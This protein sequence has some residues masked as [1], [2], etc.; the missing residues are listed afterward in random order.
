MIS[1]QMTSKEI[2]ER[3]CADGDNVWQTGDLSLRRQLAIII[4]AW[5]DG[6]KNIIVNKMAGKGDIVDH[7]VFGDYDLV[8]WKVHGVDT[9]LDPRGFM[10]AISINSGQNDPTDPNTQRVK[11]PGTF[12]GHIPG[13][14]MTEI[15]QKWID[16][17]GRIAV[18]TVDFS[19]LQSYR[20]ILSWAGFTITDIIAGEPNRGFYIE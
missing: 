14:S 19:K 2:I 20:N 8:L 15:L 7:A 9:G 13:S 10:F 3:L 18:G 5:T 17:Y 6:T 1:E 12:I 4:E 11:F 16:S